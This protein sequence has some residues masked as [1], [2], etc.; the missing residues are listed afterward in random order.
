M[1]RIPPLKILTEEQ[2]KLVQTDWDYV[3]TQAVEILYN[4]FEKYPG[5]MKH[6]KAFAGKD[7]DDLKDT[8]EF[9]AHAEKILG[10]FGQVI[11]LL[12]KDIEGIKKILNEMGNNHKARGTSRFAFLE[13]REALMEF[14]RFNVGS[15]YDGMQAWTDAIDCMYHIIYNNL[16]GNPV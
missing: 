8:P 15:S 10:V 2:A 11:D 3:R 9:A 6:F 14:L 12:G 16:E 4:F 5:N 1:A 7:L 13:F